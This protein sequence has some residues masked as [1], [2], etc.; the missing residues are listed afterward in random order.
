[1]LGRHLDE[2][3]EDGAV[4]AERLTQLSDE[5]TTPFHI[6]DVRFRE[7]SRRGEL[8]AMV[9][10]RFD[11][12]LIAEFETISNTITAYNTLYPMVRTFIGHLQGAND[13]DELCRLSVAE[14][15][16]VT[17]FGRVKIY[18]FDADGNG[19]VHAECRDDDYPSYLGLS[20]PCLL[21]TSDAADE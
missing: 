13:I 9:A 17:G 20:F 14:V 10:H 6:G 16:R 12:V 18:S 21:Y 15:K 19:L 8:T 11:Q 3:L 7:G 4:L 1:M 2:L 5:D